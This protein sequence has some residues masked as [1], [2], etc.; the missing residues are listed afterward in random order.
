MTAEQVA[1]ETQAQAPQDDQVAVHDAQLPEADGGGGA[2][3]AGQIDILLDATVQVNVS[4]G[5]TEMKIRQLLQLG[6]G[7][8]VPLDKR[9]G[10]PL[11]LFLRGKRFATGELVVVGD[12]LG[13]RIKEI[14]QPAI[15]D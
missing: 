14:L 15:G 8:V 4:I 9:I 1:N 6:E 11:D 12:Q 13:V 2:A 7:T 10:E 5:Q 3:G